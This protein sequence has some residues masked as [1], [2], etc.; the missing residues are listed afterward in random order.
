MNKLTFKHL[1]DDTYFEQRNFDDKKRLESFHQENVFINQYIK[2]GCICDVGCSTGEFLTEVNWEGTK[3]GMEINDKA[4]E[5]AM[6]NGINFDKNILNQE[7]FFD[8]VVFRGT[9]QH[10]PNPF[11]YIQNAFNSL[12]PGGYIVFLSTP[13]TSSIYY[14]VFNDLPML[15]DSLNFFVPSS[16]V[17][18]NVLKNLNF[19]I[20]DIDKP[21]IKSPYAN[22]L[23]DHLKFVKKLFFRTNDKFAFWGNSMNLIAQKPID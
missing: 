19:K 13:N 14:K 6:K 20:I 17:L 15:D 7:S 10:L 3:Y 18:C 16:K 5:L 2:S 21:Y 11:Y 1:Y 23:L 8:I 9:I 4:K 12:K 22:L